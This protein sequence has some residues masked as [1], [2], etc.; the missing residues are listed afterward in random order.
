MS[1]GKL[2]KPR[3]P[4]NGNKSAGNNKP[5]LIEPPMNTDEIR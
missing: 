5:N 3:K 2:G 4:G 1:P